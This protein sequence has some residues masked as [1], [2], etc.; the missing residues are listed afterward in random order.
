MLRAIFLPFIALV[1]LAG[2]ETVAG[3][4]QDLEAAGDAITEESNE[5][6]ADI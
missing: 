1:A 2:C 3:A 4:G 6:Q 5:V